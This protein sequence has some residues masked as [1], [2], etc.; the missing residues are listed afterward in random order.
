M[1]TASAVITARASVPIKPK[2]SATFPYSFSVATKSL[3]SNLIVIDVCTV[4]STRHI[5]ESPIRAI[6]RAAVVAVAAATDVDAVTVTS[7]AP[8][9][10]PTCRSRRRRYTVKEGHVATIS[11]P[12]TSG[13]FGDRSGQWWQL[14]RR[15]GRGGRA[16]AKAAAPLVKISGGGCVWLSG[17]K[18]QSSPKPAAT[19]AQERRRRPSVD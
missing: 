8:P 1:I 3:R 11:A 9:Q 13:R 7:R 10:S 12:S 2:I 18:L 16:R 17:G 15:V 14:W 4:P 6:D 19:R 5:G